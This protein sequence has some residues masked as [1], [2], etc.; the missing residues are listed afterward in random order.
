MCF[1]DGDDQ[2]TLRD[3]LQR[4]M[5]PEKEGS[6]TASHEGGSILS[7]TRE[8]SFTRGDSFTKM[9]SKSP[10]LFDAFRCCKK[11]ALPQREKVLIAAH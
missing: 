9:Q 1:A 4:L 8:G 5:D 7:V 10:E 3:R 2:P 6:F 11:E